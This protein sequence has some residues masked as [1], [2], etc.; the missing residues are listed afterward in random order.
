VLQ[1]FAAQI[2]D[3]FVEC[4]CDPLAILPPV[5]GLAFTGMIE[6]RL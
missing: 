4:Q 1:L 2:I 3:M 6:S 5:P